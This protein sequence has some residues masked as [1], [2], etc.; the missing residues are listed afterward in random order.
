MAVMEMH[1]KISEARDNNYFSIGVF[2]D[3]SKAFDTVNHKILLKKLE[4]CGIRGICLDWLTDYLTDRRQCVSFNGHVSQISDIKCGVPQG[5]ILG[6][7]LFLI[8][9]KDIS[10]ASSL[11]HFIMFA[12]DTNVF[13]S[14]KS[15]DVLIKTINV[16]LKHVGEW[17][18]ANKLSLNLQKTNFI[19]FNSKRKTE[20]KLDC[21]LTINR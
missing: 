19:L 1:D 16:E 7:L 13:M 8:Y 12:D 11:L 4:H 3:L 10:N 17:F 6:P 20:L 21:D 15:I 14:N 18:K 2:F 9:M 5:S